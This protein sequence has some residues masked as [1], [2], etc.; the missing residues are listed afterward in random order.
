MKFLFAFKL[1]FILFLFLF[2]CMNLEQSSW[3][4]INQLGYL[5]QSKK[6]AVLGSKHNIQ[7]TSF[8]L[9]D[10]I[11]DAVPIAFLTTLWSETNE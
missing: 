4:R 7:C 3:I 9:I 6:V 1:H 2:S 8:S 10:A 11:A 5:P